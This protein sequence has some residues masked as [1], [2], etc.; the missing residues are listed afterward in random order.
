[1]IHCSPAMIRRLLGMTQSDACSRGHKRGKKKPVA[2]Q[3]HRKQ[4]S[5]FDDYGSGGRHGSPC[6]PDWELG[7]PTSPK[8]RRPSS[9]LPGISPAIQKL[10]PKPALKASHTSPRGMPNLAGVSSHGRRNAL[11]H[12]C[13]HLG[14]HS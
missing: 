1:M 2:L 14:L 5:P 7:V 6:Q 8:G 9:A 12:I 10:S 3:L 13:Y 11:H 4:P